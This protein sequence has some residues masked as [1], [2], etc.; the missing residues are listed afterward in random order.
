MT[1][2]LP[3]RKRDDDP[4]SVHTL[5][6]FQRRYKAIRN[7]QHFVICTKTIG[8]DRKAIFTWSEYTNPFF[9]THEAALAIILKKID[10]IVSV[11]A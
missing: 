3:I 7:F 1:P 6:D 5:H 10:P 4:L 2:D 11:K 9:I 8:S